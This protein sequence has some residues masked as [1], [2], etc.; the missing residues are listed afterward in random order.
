[1]KRKMGQRVIIGLNQG[2]NWN[3]TKDALLAAGAELVLDPSGPKPDAL[4][5]VIN[6]SRNMDEFLTIAR[7]LDGVRYAEPDAWRV[8]F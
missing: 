3:E 7:K 2:T 4:V 8:S 1:M 6:S 5:A